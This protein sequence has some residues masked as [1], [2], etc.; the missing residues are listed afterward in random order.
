MAKNDI[1]DILTLEAKCLAQNNNA[2]IQEAHEKLAAAGP[3]PSG[4]RELINLLD[5]YDTPEAQRWQQALLKVWRGG[6]RTAARH[7]GVGYTCGRIPAQPGR[8]AWMPENA[9]HA[10]LYCDP[11]TRGY[12]I[13]VRGPE[14]GCSSVLSGNLTWRTK[15][16]SRLRG[17]YAAL[18]PAVHSQKNRPNFTV[19]GCVG[20]W[21]VRVW[22]AS[23]P[24][25][26]AFI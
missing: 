13:P 24:P 9:P 20:T 19:S 26:S 2:K 8:T 14:H 18:W 3:L 23:R 1:T 7:D 25:M 15:Q 6:Y 11:K 5:E 12:G 16:P 22:L 10:V 4:V 17:T 21:V